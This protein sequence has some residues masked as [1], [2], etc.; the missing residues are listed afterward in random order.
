MNETPTLSQRADALEEKMSQE[1]D[2]IV[3]KSRLY[4]MAEEG[5]MGPPPNAARLMA[6]NP[7]ARVLMGDDPRL[8]R[9]AGRSQTL[10][11]FFKCRFGPAAHLLQSA[12][13]AVNAGLPDNM[14]LACLCTTSRRSVSSAAI[15]A[16]GAPNSWS[17]TS[18]KK[19][20]GPSA[21]T[22][23]CAST[24]TSRWATNIRNPTSKRSAPITGR[25]HI[26]MKIISGCETTNGTMS[27]RMITVHDI[28]SFDPDAKV[29]LEEFTDVIGRNF[30]QPEQRILGF[31]NSPV[32]HMWRA[33]IRPAKYL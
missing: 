5:D 23:C 1:L 24:L 13:H 21:P 31:D 4:S 25:I 29:E 18:T 27:G 2:Y 6:A 3:I 32:A 14:V 30:R 16:T 15:T 20:P 26:S 9:D 11:D 19:L 17:P 12:K 8:A 22:R 33:M 7:N 28:C 10:M